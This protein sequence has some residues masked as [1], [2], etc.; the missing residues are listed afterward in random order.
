MDFKIDKHLQQLEIFKQRIPWNLFRQP[1]FCTRLWQEAFI[2]DNGDVYPCCHN[3]PWK[4][5]NLHKSSLKE[6]W[7]NKRIHGARLLSLNHGLY[8]REK[9]T[10]LDE[11]ERSAVATSKE[12]GQVEYRKLRRIKILFGQLCN[13]ECIMC[14]QNHLS[15]K[16]LS[17]D[18]LRDKVD[19]THLEDIEFQ[20]GEPLAMKE[21]K[22]AYL[23]LTEEMGKKVNFL[24]NG[25]L[26]TD[27]WAE[28]IVK[29]STWLYFSINGATRETFERVNHGAKLDKITQN[30]GRVLNARARANSEIALVGHFTMVK[31]N[32]SE[33]DQFPALAAKMGFDR[34][35]FGFDMSTIPKWMRD[36]PE[37]KTRLRESFSALME[38]PP[39]P[40][41]IHRLK[42]LGLVD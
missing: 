27:K 6:I 34:V 37:E 13:L 22:N 2:T 15:N 40:I 39:V 24:T 1:T 5:G 25:T 26:I 30:L 31:D 28:R 29:G 35:E 41:R 17:F 21:C 19:W 36:N 23:W 32:I 14:N 7:N 42:Y 4:Y 8:C 9:C 20:G 18:L 12:K 3:L 11:T 16:Q 33:V 10:L 38:D